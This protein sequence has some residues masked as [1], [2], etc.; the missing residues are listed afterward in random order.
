MKVPDTGL[1]AKI[2]HLLAAGETRS[3]PIADA[4]S[5]SRRMLQDHL[6]GLRARGLV[7]ARSRGTWTLTGAGQRAA[8]DP[9]VPE[10]VGATEALTALPA[11][12]RAVL[13]LI[14]D[15][16]IARRALGEVHPSNWP[17]FILRGP[18]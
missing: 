4:L 17:G 8:L 2:L 18:T 15:A 14:E 10:P 9:T 7:E 3:A 11:E 5:K 12:H 13:R 1:D 16:V 6:T